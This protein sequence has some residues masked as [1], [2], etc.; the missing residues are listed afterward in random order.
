MEEEPKSSFVT[1][2]SEGEK[3]CNAGDYEKALDSYNTVSI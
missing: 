3:L 1:Y 2:L